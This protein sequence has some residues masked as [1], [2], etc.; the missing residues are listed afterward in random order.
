MI[1]QCVAAFV[2]ERDFMRAAGFAAAGAALTFFGFM[3]GERIGIGE[4]PAVAA[5]YLAIAVLF[6][7][8]AKFAVQ[9]RTSAVVVPAH[10]ELQT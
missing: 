8:C 3:H 5:G 1:E 9:E 6:V 7:G 2:I 4:T 10:A